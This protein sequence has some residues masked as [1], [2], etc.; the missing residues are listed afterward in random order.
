MVDKISSGETILL[1]SEGGSEV[2]P[3]E[4]IP[5]K[6]ESCG[7]FIRRYLV[8]HKQ[9][10][11]GEIHRSYKNAYKY[12]MK[13]SDRKRYHVGTYHSF[14]TY[15]N[16][17][18]KIGLLT[19]VKQRVKKRTTHPLGL[20]LDYPEVTMLRL[21]TKGKGAPDLVWMHPLKMWYRPQGWELEEY[22][23]YTKERQE[24]T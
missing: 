1:S 23:E 9:G 3:L 21:S 7:M 22:P 13:L 19:V 24:E 15:T 8:E 4:E 20:A 18:V 10:Y 12:W 2:I 5:P 11:A 14:A 17:L 16:K 6:P